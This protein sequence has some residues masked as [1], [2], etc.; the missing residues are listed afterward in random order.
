MSNKTKEKH[1]EKQKEHRKERRY[2]G[3]VLGTIA[4]KNQPKPTA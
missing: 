4:K 1:V 2:R 3:H